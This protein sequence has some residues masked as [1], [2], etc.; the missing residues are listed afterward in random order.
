M[1]NNNNLIK[2]RITMKKIPLWATLLALSFSLSY[3]IEA[4]NGKGFKTE[5]DARLGIVSL[6]NKVFG[7]ENLITQNITQSEKDSWVLVTQNLKDFI[8][9]T[10]PDLSK[11]YTTAEK[12]SLDFISFLQ[13]AFK[14]YIKPALI[15]PK[16][17]EE[18]TSR[19]LATTIDATA[20]DIDGLKKQLSRL[21]G[22]LSAL[23][24]L[25][26]RVK[27]FK[28]TQ[29]AEVEAKLVLETFI[30]AVQLSVKKALKDLEKLR[31]FKEKQ[32]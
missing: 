25:E 12:I 27:G 32:S 17:K 15:N 19:L 24:Q 26:E 20:L 23:K 28:S 21:K 10:S 31:A 18:G 13:N 2:K 7:K 29:K 3:S 16:D 5:E 8:E 6:H 11:V 9:R 4:T 1:Y 22:F 14:N 30:I